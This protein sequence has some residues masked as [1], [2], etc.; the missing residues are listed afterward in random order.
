MY[1]TLGFLQNLGLGEMLIIGAIALLI[2][3]PQLPKVARWLGK[4][5]TEFKKGMTDIADE[6]TKEPP[7]E[8][9]DK[10]KQK[11]EKLEG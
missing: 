5:V 3:G 4:S 10:A 8:D 11:S 6:V 9:Q 1:T 2:F 7:R